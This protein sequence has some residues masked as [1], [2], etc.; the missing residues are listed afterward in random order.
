MQTRDNQEVRPGLKVWWVGGG[1]DPRHGA[2]VR[3]G[4]VIAIGR[5]KVKLEV[6][7]KSRA[8]YQTATTSFQFA[9]WLWASEEGCRGWAKTLS[10]EDWSRY[11]DEYLK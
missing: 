4:Q 2:R 10:Y 7:S 6:I 9:D 11:A 8:K 3:H 1:Y 5:K